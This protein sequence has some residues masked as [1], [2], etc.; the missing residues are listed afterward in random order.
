[1]ME[2]FSSDFGVSCYLQKLPTQVHLVAA[3][4]MA[5]LGS[6]FARSFPVRNATRAACRLNLK[7][8]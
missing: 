2:E 6:Q 8:L 4:G 1:M 3:F 5:T 7:V